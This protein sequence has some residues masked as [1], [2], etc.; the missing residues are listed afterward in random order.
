MI[1]AFVQEKIDHT[2]DPVK[3]PHAGHWDMLVV[4]SLKVVGC[5][6]GWTAKNPATKMFWAYTSCKYT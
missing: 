5:S 2:K 6:M 1:Q 4:P 3:Q